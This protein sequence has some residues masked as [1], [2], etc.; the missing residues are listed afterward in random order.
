TTALHFARRRPHVL[1]RVNRPK[2][3]RLA[4]TERQKAKRAPQ[5]GRTR[6]RAI[7][8]H[9]I[10]ARSSGTHSDT[11]IASEITNSERVCP[12]TTDQ[13]NVLCL[14]V[15]TG[16]IT[17][18]EAD[19]ADED[20]G[21]LRTTQVEVIPFNSESLCILIWH[22]TAIAMVTRQKVKCTRSS[23]NEPMFRPPAG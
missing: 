10:S 6:R 5:N 7:A 23:A 2:Q 18:G 19:G 11:N 14:K 20:H 13:R 9:A 17:S 21:V 15:K 3:T 1:E 8:G 12:E 4:D 22:G 16:E